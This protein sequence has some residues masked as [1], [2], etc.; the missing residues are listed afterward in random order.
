MFWQ[1]RPRLTGELSSKC[2]DPRAGF[3]SIANTLKAAKARNPFVSKDEVKQFFETLRDRQNRPQRGYNSF[4]SQE[5]MHEVQVDLAFMQNFGPKPVLKHPCVRR[6]TVQ[7]KRTKLHMQLQAQMPTELGNYRQSKAA[8]KLGTLAMRL[9]AKSPTAH[10]P[11]RK[12][13]VEPLLVKSRSETSTIC[14][15]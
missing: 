11:A 1:E 12:A 8:G 2:T 14:K 15:S 5:P 3:G 10:D 6:D 4:V 9:V 7:V 13:T